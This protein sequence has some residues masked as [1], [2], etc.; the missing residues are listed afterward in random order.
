MKAQAPRSTELA[1]RIRRDII[2]QSHR[3]NVGHI[4]SALCIADLLA[5]LFGGWLRLDGD[6]RDRFTLSKGHAALA[7]YA[8]LEATGRLPEGSVQTYCAEGTLLGVHPDVALD[9]IDFSTGSLGQGLSMATG[10]ALA[11]KMQGSGR[12][13][14]R[15]SIPSMRPAA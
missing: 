13:W 1:A 9:G 12:R 10:A 3:A 5:V 2:E 4:G 15:A 7:L 14:P 11:A 6:D 8:A